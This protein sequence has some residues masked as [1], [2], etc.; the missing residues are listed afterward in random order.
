MYQK[1]F[2]ITI[3]LNYSSKNK[4]INR[5]NKQDKWENKKPIA[6]K[7]QFCFKYFPLK[8]YFNGLM[9]FFLEISLGDNVRMQLWHIFL[10]KI[11]TLQFVFNYNNDINGNNNL[12]INIHWVKSVRIRSFS[13]SYFPIFELNTERCSV[14]IRKN[15]DQKNSKHGHFLRSDSFSN[16]YITLISY[17]EDD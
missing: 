5:T 16:L 13:G 14:R 2:S 1:F 8:L 11:Q 10:L 17:M 12:I 3:F 9:F 6:D 15:T 4:L 7:M